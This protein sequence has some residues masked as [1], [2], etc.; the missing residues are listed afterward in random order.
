[1]GEMEEFNLTPLAK[2]WVVEQ[3]LEFVQDKPERVKYFK[4]DVREFNDFLATYIHDYLNMRG[5]VAAY[6][7]T[8]TSLCYSRSH[9]Y[10]KLK[11]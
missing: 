5:T 4:F 8:A 3:F 2:Q 9:M 11:K 6:D 1:M 10:K 7:K